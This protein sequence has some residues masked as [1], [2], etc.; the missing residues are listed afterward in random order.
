LALLLGSFSSNVLEKE[1]DD[2]EN[3][4]RVAIDRIQR[5]FDFLIKFIFRRKKK[6]NINDTQESVSNLPLPTLEESN[7]NDLSTTNED[8]EMQ[9]MNNNSIKSP[10]TWQILHMPP[11]CCPTMISKHF[12]CCAKCI[13]K[14]IQERWTYLRSLAHCFVEHRFF[15]W[16]IIVIILVSSITLVS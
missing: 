15:E 4:I 11:D 10:P 1:D 16:F 7:A 3:K 5:F 8:I 13:P 12:S 6:T 14:C 9:P 2:D